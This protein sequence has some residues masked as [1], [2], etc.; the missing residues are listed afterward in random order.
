MGVAMRSNVAIREMQAADVDQV[1]DLKWAMN[2]L[3]AAFQSTGTVLD[4]D[5]V[6]DREAATHAIARDQARVLT[7]GG[8]ILVGEMDARI[9]GYVCWY[10][11]EGSVSLRPAA[12]RIGYIGGICIGE[13]FRGQGIGTDLLCEVERRALSAGVTRL[14]IGVHT[15]NQAAL[16]LYE[17][18]GFFGQQLHMQK[19]LAQ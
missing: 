17:R 13:P 8:N 11:D 5:I 6:E 19:P 10:H 15:C 12:Q 4:H 9:V 2:R 7:R 14:A 16:R 18:L 3:H 1:I